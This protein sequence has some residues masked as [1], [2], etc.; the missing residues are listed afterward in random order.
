M[1]RREKQVLLE[2]THTTYWF[3]SPTSTYQHRFKNSTDVFDGVGTTQ[4]PPQNYLG[5]EKRLGCIEN[6]EPINLEPNRKNPFPTDE[7]QSRA[8]RTPLIP[9]LT[10]THNEEAQ[11]GEVTP[12]E[13]TSQNQNGTP[14]WG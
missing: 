8:A 10:P 11:E 9:Y 13:A 14:S 6:P 1:F 5:T 4:I 12:Y 2:L 3:S 7:Y